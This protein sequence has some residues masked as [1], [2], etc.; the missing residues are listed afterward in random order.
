LPKKSETND[1]MVERKAINDDG[2][3]ISRQCGKGVVERHLVQTRNSPIFCDW[4]LT[5]HSSDGTV[6]PDPT[7]GQSNAWM[8]FERQDAHGA[9]FAMLRVRSITA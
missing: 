2:L 8:W 6:R 7:F 5:L 3:Q 9:P 4:P 1:N